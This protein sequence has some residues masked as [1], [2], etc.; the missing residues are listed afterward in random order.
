M[1]G[2]KTLKDVLKTILV[3]KAPVPLSFHFLS[4]PF[5]SPPGV[6]PLVLNFVNRNLQ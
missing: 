4:F 2:F 1:H 3:L 6:K 5:L